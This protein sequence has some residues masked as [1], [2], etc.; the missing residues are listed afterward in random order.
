MRAFCQ[1]VHDVAAREWRTGDG[2]L[3]GGTVGFNLSQ[4]Y[5]HISPGPR[6][7]PR[8]CAL[9]DFS[10][11]LSREIYECREHFRYLHRGRALFVPPCKH[12]FIAFNV[13]G[14]IV[15][16]RC[17]DVCEIVCAFLKPFF[18]QDSITSQ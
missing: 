9:N 1:K 13:I 7:H 16:H 18:I 12:C 4:L 8:V 10:N 2:L 3:R 17:L 15:K 11:P 6:T 5:Y 14:N